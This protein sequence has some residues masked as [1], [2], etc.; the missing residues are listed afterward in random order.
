MQIRS[1]AIVL[2]KYNIGEYDCVCSLFSRNCGKIRVAV[3]NALRPKNRSMGLFEPFNVLDIEL[4]LKENRDLFRLSEAKLL[5]RFPSL[6]L[7]IEKVTA[8]FEI[9]EI[10]DRFTADSESNPTLY[11]LAIDSLVSLSKSCFLDEFTLRLFECQYLLTNGYSMNVHSCARCGQTRDRHAARYHASEGGIVCMKCSPDSNFDI[12]SAPSLQII[13][14]LSDRKP[15]PQLD[16]R[17][18]EIIQSEL[19]TVIMRSFEY[20]FSDVPRTW[21]QSNLGVSGSIA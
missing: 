7:T 15:I 19:R 20:H 14:Y 16:R 2:R 12:M 8:A 13:Q 18:Q 17:K 6:I 5:Q 4:F 3:K 9:I 1:E 21:Q 10:L 11:Q